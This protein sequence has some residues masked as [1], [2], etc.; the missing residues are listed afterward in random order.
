MSAERAP[1]GVV[2]GRSRE[3][4]NNGLQQ[5]LPRFLPTGIWRTNQSKKRIQVVSC[6]GTLRYIKNLH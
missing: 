1:N 6:D 5:T 3:P 2:D 4:V